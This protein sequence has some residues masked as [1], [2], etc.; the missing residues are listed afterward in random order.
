MSQRIHLDLP[1]EYLKGVGPI[2]GSLLRKQ[3]SI[4][5]LSDLIQ[6]FP[7]RYVD[8][9]EYVAIRD[10]NIHAD[11]VQIKAKLISF[12]EDGQGKAKRLIAQVE[13]HSGRLELIWFQGFHGF[14]PIF[15]KDKNM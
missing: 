5:K 15:I 6:Y 8:K 12:Q 10:I 9:T 7:F 2:K 1:I 11:A 13:D 14:Y 3:L 4:D